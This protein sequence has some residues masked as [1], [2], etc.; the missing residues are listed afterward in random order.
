MMVFT[1]K[2]TDLGTLW[3]QLRDLNAWK[4]VT[5]AG[6]ELGGKDESVVKKLGVQSRTS[7]KQGK[8]KPSLQY[9]P[10]MKPSE[11]MKAFNPGGE[12]QS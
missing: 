6:C 7:Q 11:G 8:N 2:I 9:S 4:R 1:A 5:Y 12:P 10:W 3:F